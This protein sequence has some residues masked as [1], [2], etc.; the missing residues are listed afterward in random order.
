MRTSKHRYS[1]VQPVQRA[2]PILEE[3]VR[4]RK[5]VLFC[6]L[7][8]GFPEPESD[9]AVRGY[10]KHAARFGCTDIEIVALYSCRLGDPAW[11]PN[12]IDRCG[13]GNDDA[14]RAAA[15][16]ADLVVAAWG[17]LKKW[18]RRRAEYVTKILAAHRDVYALGGPTADGGPRK[19]GSAPADAPLRLH[20]PK[21]A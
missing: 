18:T 10:A 6:L 14:I 17:P 4:E 13:P 1:A 9:P 19:P 16:R 3:P 12:M 8:P 7:H 15:A 5:R 21:A 20:A 11:L 2:N